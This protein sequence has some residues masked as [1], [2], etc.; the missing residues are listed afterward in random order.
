MQAARNAEKYNVF[1][2]WAVI[3][4]ERDHQPASVAEVRKLGDLV[5]ETGQAEIGGGRAELEH[6]GLSCHGG[7]GESETEGE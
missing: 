3:A 5:V 7:L 6:R 2:E 4:D 1:D